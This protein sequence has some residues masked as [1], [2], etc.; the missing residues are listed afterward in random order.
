M[1][2]LVREGGSSCGWDDALHRLA[3]ARADAIPTTGSWARRRNFRKST[4]I[5]KIHRRN[6]SKKSASLW[7]EMYVCPKAL[8]MHTRAQKAWASRSASP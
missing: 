7:R 8:S 5:L 3:G 6:I 1:A 2:Q 4:V